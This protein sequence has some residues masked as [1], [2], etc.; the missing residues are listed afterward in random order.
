MSKVFC[1]ARIAALQSRRHA[2]LYPVTQGERED[3]AS[4]GVATPS[5]PPPD[6]LRPA[7]LQSYS[8]LRESKTV[9]LLCIPVITGTYKTSLKADKE[10]GG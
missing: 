1:Q 3:A 7:I 8:A 2:A 5:L 4:T 10:V 9:H 6:G